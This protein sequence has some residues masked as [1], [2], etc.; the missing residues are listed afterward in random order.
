M[1]ALLNNKT[2]KFFRLENQYHN[3]HEVDT[4]IE[5]KTFKTKKDAA[6]NNCLINGDYR[7]ID[8]NEAKEM[9]LL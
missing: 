4:F 1:Y 5:A 3:C 2:K 6:Y 8:I 9:N 7:I